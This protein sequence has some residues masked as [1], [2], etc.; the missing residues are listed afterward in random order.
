MQELCIP[1]ASVPQPQLTVVCQGCNW[2]QWPRKGAWSP[3]SKAPKEL[4]TWF[5]GSRQ[6][7]SWVFIASPGPPAGPAGILEYLSSASHSTLTTVSP[8]RTACEADPVRSRSHPAPGRA[9]P[10][11]GIEEPKARSQGGRRGQ[12]LGLPIPLPVPVP[13][14][15]LLQRPIAQRN[16][17]T[18]ESMELKT[19]FRL[20]GQDFPREQTTLK[21]RK[22]KP[23]LVP[24]SE[25]N[26]FV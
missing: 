9:R 16:H 18:Q 12:N 22:K 4:R 5:L 19:S 1:T 17:R 3:L 26:K 10:V 6:S 8:R 15:F 20:W 2:A 25:V 11:R 13:G 21:P 23:V 24:E 14:E 7:S